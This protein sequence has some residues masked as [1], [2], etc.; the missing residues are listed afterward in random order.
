MG[1]NSQPRFQSPAGEQEQ[2]QVIID[3]NISNV[4]K[5][6]KH[7]KSMN[8]KRKQ[9]GV[10]KELDQVAENEELDYSPMITSKK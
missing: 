10:K 5:P 7:S 8:S 1:K 3:L 2:E 6:Q 9:Q 4:K